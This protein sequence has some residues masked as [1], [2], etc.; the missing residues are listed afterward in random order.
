MG[1]FLPPRRAWEPCFGQ[2]AA[3]VS[4]TPSCA[5]SATL[6]T[7]CQ[8][9]AGVSDLQHGR[10]KGVPV[11]WAQPAWDGSEELQVPCVSRQ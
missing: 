11:P 10:S 5:P 4:W 7:K 3:D 8:E 9:D 1:I 2:D 6:V